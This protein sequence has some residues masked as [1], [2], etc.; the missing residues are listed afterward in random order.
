MF[1]IQYFDHFLLV[2]VEAEVIS[3][4]LLLGEGGDTVTLL[5]ACV[6]G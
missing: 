4:Q 1:E 2:C 3:F 6:I 5:D